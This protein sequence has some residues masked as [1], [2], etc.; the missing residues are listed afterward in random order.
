MALFLLSGATA[1]VYQ[2]L[3]LR[4]LILVFG[5]TLFA[6]SSILSTFMGGL[7][8]GAYLAGRSMDRSR[9]SPLL[10]YGMLECAI[11]GYA[12]L[13]PFLFRA[14]TPIYQVVWDAG[15]AD[16]Q[17]MLNLAKFAG[18]ALIL[19]PPTTLM[20]ASLPVLSRAVADDPQ[21]IG[22][23][24][25]TLYA[26]NTFGAVLGTFLA[27]FLAIVTLGVLHTLWITAAT[28]LLLG[29][30]AI[31]LGKRATAPLPPARP[32]EQPGR[33][34][35]RSAPVRIT[36]IAF[37]ISGF[38]AMVLEVAWTRALGLVLGSSVY[39]F[40]LMLL[41]FLIGL[42]AGGAFFSWMLKRRPDTDI[43]AL[44][45]FLFGGTGI[46]AFTTAYIL[47]AL[48]GYFGF[49]HFH[50]SPGPNVWYLVQF[51]F[52]LMVM[53]PATFAFGGIFPAV[54][55]LHARGLQHVAG[56]VGTVYASNTIGTILGAAMAGFL[57]IP[58]LGVVDSV[59]TVAVVQLLLGILMVLRVCLSSGRRRTLLGAVL[60]AGLCAVFLL[61]PGWDVRMM[62]SGVY[63]NLSGLGEKATWEDFEKKIY[64][65]NEVVYAKE[66][67]TAA[68]L[69]GYEPEY[70]NY[71]LA[72]NGKIEASTQGDMD[73]QLLAAHLPLLL[74]EEPADVMLIGLAS[75]ITAGSALTHPIKSL[76]IVEVE[77]AMEDAARIF[78]KQNRHA[79]DDPRVTLSINDARNELVFSPDTYDV[80]ISE[81]SNPWMTVASNL[82]TEEFFA[83]SRTRLRPSGIFCQWVQ[84][85]HLA[86]DDLLSI[87]GAFHSAY[88]YVY[89]FE[90]FD[91][92]DNLLLGS[93]R[94][95]PLDLERID[96]RMME[97]QVRIDLARISVRSPEDL[98]AHFRVGAREVDGMVKNAPR[99][100]DDNARVEFA[101]PRA[102]YRNNI[103]EN[104]TFL[105]NH[106]SDI[107]DYVK[108]L[109]SDPLEQDRLL[110]RLARAWNRQG[111]TE[112]A[113]ALARRIA[114]GPLASEAD[115]L[116]NQQDMR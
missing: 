62:N 28:N 29:V 49:V 11:G 16:S 4:Q 9:R 12:L 75:G 40:S 105:A 90:T 27:G 109:P 41:A 6:T 24:V 54:L 52:C 5:S 76:K 116:L 18:I 14:L 38:G 103:A 23:N 79:L 78:D 86:E 95:I 20:G 19:L 47:Q 102:L 97:L 63:M 67:L 48:P 44:L 82:F 45:A 32:S 101:A 64:E 3:W 15:G 26:V 98:I 59:L 37:G 94:P 8:L 100:T 35:T 77:A 87:I 84:N 70:D 72:V 91:G 96:E 13:V 81:P 88:P 53:F 92:I 114:D 89:V 51:G 113:R 36:L 43:G 112:K 1:L 57:L 42:A 106:S 69:V 115:H 50:Y 2:V 68:V 33:E 31:R 34:K 99:N 73:T 22:G 46:L 17:L 30:I 110:L 61:R 25:G 56:S 55:Q 111:F 107:L 21:R 60:L 80:I 39:A 7:A 71:Y 83:L 65:N 10:V 85:Y 58:K 108:L 74:Q 66:G 93:D 104:L